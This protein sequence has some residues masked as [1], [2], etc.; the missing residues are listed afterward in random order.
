MANPTQIHQIIMNLC[1]NAAHAM[2]AD[3][4][5]LEVI[6]EP[7]DSQIP[8][9]LTNGK[10]KEGPYIKLS[11]TDTGAGMD[12]QV[13]GR[14]FEPY[15][16]TKTKETGTGLGL[17]VVHGI[18]TAHGGAVNVHSEP[19][20]G[21][22]FDVYFPRINKNLLYAEKKS[23]PLPRGDERILFVDDEEGLINLVTRML[24]FLGYSVVA[25]TN[26][27]EAL[28]LFRTQPD[29][30]DLVITDLTMPFMTGDKLAQELMKTRPDIP[31]ILCS[32]Y[33]EKF[34]KQKA[35]EIGIRTFL[36]KPIV[37]KDMAEIVRQVLD[38]TKSGD[39]T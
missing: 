8:R 30:F 36:M 18:V 19:G 1:T 15:Y 26:G 7:F 6:L 20:K 3:G 25:K 37:L 11:V 34:S 29:R 31:V 12:P 22:V 32:G 9:D 16:T 38:E 4:G 14:I 33:K 17:A 13:L 39:R 27:K 35:K 2:E 21:S 5:T 24:G 28:D 10:L 23:V